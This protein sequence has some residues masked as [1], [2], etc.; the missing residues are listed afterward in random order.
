MIR[1]RHAAMLAARRSGVANG[2]V[3][4]PVMVGILRGAYVL[5]VAN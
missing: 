2:S 3:T 1:A 4:M 5:R